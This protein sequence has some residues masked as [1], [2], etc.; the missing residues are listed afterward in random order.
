MSFRALR[1]MVVGLVIGAAGCGTNGVGG[2]D[3]G[4]D[5]GG[6]GENADVEQCATAERECDAS[7]GWSQ[8][9]Q[10]CTVNDAGEEEWTACCGWGDNPIGTPYC[11]CT[12]PWM[13][14]DEEQCS[15]PLVLA[16]E[17]ERVSYTTEMAGSFD[18]TGKGMSVASDWP[19]ART[20]W[21]ALD[22][23]G[24]GLIDGGGELFGSATVLANGEHASN[25][26][27]AL[28]EL[29]DD[30]NG[31][32]DARDA[33]F[34]RLVVWRDADASRSSEAGELSP[35]SATLV[36]I[37]LGYTKSARCDERGNCEIERAAFRHVDAAGR[38]QTGTVIDVHLR[39]Q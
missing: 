16:F 18:L 35:A 15:T 20:P 14:L 38:E 12:P 7:G 19:T 6:D 9:I 29:D 17:N 37:D 2:G 11:E 10:Y 26:F 34:S 36:S 13:E 5:D 39:R 27:V 4:D 32:I 8:G 23:D 31:L 25:G 28:A 33:V 30:G 21:L 1:M 24:N 3:D 22:R